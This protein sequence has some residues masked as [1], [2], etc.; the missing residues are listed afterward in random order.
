MFLIE[1]LWVFLLLVLCGTFVFIFLSD[2]VRV[3]RETQICC[4]QE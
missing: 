4:S 2:T 3:A 1:A